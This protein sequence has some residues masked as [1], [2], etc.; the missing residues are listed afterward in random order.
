ML[1]VEVDP[2]EFILGRDV[3]SLSLAGF[4]GACLPWPSSGSSRSLPC[5]GLQVGLVLPPPFLTRDRQ[6]S[7]LECLDLG[8]F[9]AGATLRRLCGVTGLQRPLLI[10]WASAVAWRIASCVCGSDAPVFFSARRGVFRARVP[11]SCVISQTWFGLANYPLRFWR[12]QN[13]WCWRATPPEDHFSRGICGRI[14]SYRGPC[15]GYSP[16]L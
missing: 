2:S 7:L 13:S 15:Q 16:V 14:F 9:A 6:Q 4:S 10:A 3:G 11:R 1:E 8:Q 5:R 12:N